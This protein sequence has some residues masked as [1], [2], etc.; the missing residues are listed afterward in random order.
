[1]GLDSW[2]QSLHVDIRDQRNAYGGLFFDRGSSRLYTPDMD[3][4]YHLDLRSAGFDPW[5][6]D[7]WNAHTNGVRTYAGSIDRS[8]FAT[9]SEIRHFEPIGH[10]HALSVYALQ[11]D[12][13]SARR[14]FVD[15]GYRFYLTGRHSLGISHT[16]GAFKPDLD[17]AL[18]YRGDLRSLGRLDAG[19]MMLD[20]LNNLIYDVL[21][22]DPVLDD[23]VRSYRRIPILAHARWKS[24]AALPLNVDIAAGIMPPSHAEVRRQRDPSYALDLRHLN[25]YAGVHLSRDI[26]SIILAAQHLYTFEAR[27]FV[28]PP[29]SPVLSNYRSRQRVNRS[30]LMIGGVWSVFSAHQLR[31]TVAY[32]LLRYSDSQSGTTFVESSIGRAFDL[33]ERRGEWLLSTVLVP[34]YRGLRAGLRLMTDRRNYSDGMD[35]FEGAYLRFRQW[36]PNQRLSLHVGYQARP[37]VFIEG[38]ASFDVDGDSFYTD[39]GLTRFDGGYG[40]VQ[41]TW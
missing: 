36:S 15:L 9:A 14:M 29:G 28:S 40:R 35:V 23:T 20:W 21:G 17:L 31:G 6:H 24:P 25:R 34:E 18:D 11:Q 4:E 10:R 26:G 32:E 39:R 2:L 22:V 19:V 1:V 8:A 5:W 38:G 16:A 13:L 3:H 37:G 41:F 33:D 27:S 30:S 7:G 12:D